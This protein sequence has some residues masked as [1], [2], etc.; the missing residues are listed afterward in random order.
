LAVSL[1][2]EVAARADVPVEGVV[3]VLTRQP[4]SKRIERRVVD[5]LDTLEPDQLR[6]VERL[7]RAGRP[8]VV[9]TGSELVST[10]APE[11]EPAPVVPAATPPAGRVD[12]ELLR[13]LGRLLAEIGV[14]INE[15]RRD[16][17]SAQ[18]DRV[19]DLAVLVDLVSTG[20][21]DVDR[22]LGRLERVLS[23]LESGREAPRS[24]VVPQ[25]R[26][27]A[28][29]AEA[30]APQAEPTAPPPAPPR[31]KR[32]LWRRMLAPA[33]PLLV[34]VALVLAF[35]ALELIGSDDEPR[36]QPVPEGT[37]E[38]NVPRVPSLSATTG[39]PPPAAPTTSASATTSAATT[40][41][42]RATTQQ[43]TTQRATTTTTQR[44]T[45]Q[46]TTP[47][48]G[49]SASAPA[50][51][52]AWPATVGASYYLVRIFRGTTQIHEARPAAPR[53]VLPTRIRFTKGTYRWTVQPGTGTRAQNNV[54]QP[55][56]NS[57]FEVS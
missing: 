48:P 13:E 46:P 50:R 34:V 21:R 12:D 31:K 33:M 39:G 49:A 27:L 56:V 14:G 28:P 54:G 44:T 1:L 9:P 37:S 20:W 8:E 19:D 36:L 35:L 11:P 42:P 30:P 4:V 24:Y 16:L 43:T 26:E 22:R 15:F 47:P 25:Q 6:A 53:L 23:R 41:A 57:V 18:Q 55:I 17:V 2:A 45:T 51:V 52:F 3:R 7:A 38:P 32:P 5:V 29:A 10:E 40:T